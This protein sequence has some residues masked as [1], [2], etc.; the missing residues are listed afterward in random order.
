VSTRTIHKTQGSLEVPRLL[1]SMLVTEL[2]APS[3]LVTLISPWIRDIDAVDNRAG[4][5][6]ALVPDW[7]VSLISLSELLSQL[8]S[9]GATVRVITGPDVNN[10]A[11]VEKLRLLSRSAAAQMEVRRSGREMHNKAFCGDRCV[12]TGSMNFTYAGV[13]SNSETLTYST[14]RDTIARARRGF[15]DLWDGANP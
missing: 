5:F 6:Q 13:G 7:P 15:K 11:M 10:D 4:E 8:A 12:L 2:V 1:Q 9:R 14:D 3:R